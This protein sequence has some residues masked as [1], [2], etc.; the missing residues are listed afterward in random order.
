MILF[1][2]V[3]TPNNEHHGCHLVVLY[4]V[5]EQRLVFSCNRFRYR[6]HEYHD[7]V[8]SARINLRN[9]ETYRTFS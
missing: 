9:G 2:D 3:W 6:D 7:V 1:D 8:H 5:L 4:R